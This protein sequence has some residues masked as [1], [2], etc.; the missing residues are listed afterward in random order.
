MH[1]KQIIALLTTVML[2][3]SIPASVFAESAGSPVES[4]GSEANTSIT[5]DKDSIPAE[6]ISEV[7]TDLAVSKEKAETLA[8]SHVS[9]PKEYTLQGASFSMDRLAD[10]KRGVW[11]LDFVKKV[12]GKHKG[13]IY[14][15]IHA[16]TG[17]LLEFSSYVD[18]PSAK[19]SYPL[20]V[21]RDAA[22]EIAISFI[23]KHAAEYKGQVQY[24]PDYGVQ[25]LPPLTGEVRHSIRYDRIVNGITYVDNYI[26]IEVDSEG[27]VMRFSL[28]WDDTI[29]FPK[30]ESKLTLEQANAKLSELSKP[31]LQYIIPYSGQSQRQPLLSYNMPTL[32][33]NAADGKL[34]TDPY[35]RANNVSVTPLTEKPL[36]EAPKAGSLTEK[37]ALEAITS[38]F[39]LPANA[40]LVNSNYNEYNDESSGTKQAYWN[41]NWSLK[42]GKTETG[43]VSASVDS[44]TGAVRDYYYYYYDRNNTSDKVTITYDQAKTTAIETVKKHLPWATNELYLIE[45]EEGQY[46]TIDPIDSYYLNFVRKVHGATVEYDNVSVSI[47]ARTGEIRNYNANLQDYSYPEQ[48]PKLL[49]KEQAIEKWLTFYRTELTYYLAQQYLWQGQPI[50]IEKYRAMVAAGDVEAS[51][52]EYKAEA[53]LVYRLVPRLI[54]ESIFLDAESGD[55]RNRENGEATQLEKPKATDVSGHWAQRQLELMVA[56]KALDVKDGKVRPNA[57]VTRGELIKMLVLAMNSG[58]SPIL[59]GAANDSAETKNSF[60]DVATNSSYYVYVESALQQNLIDVGDGTFNA[61]GK[62]D[63]EEMSELIVRALGYNTLANYDEL[64]NVSFKDAADTERKGQAA[65]VVGLNIMS[66]SN[67]KFLPDKQVSRAEASVAFFRFLQTRADL[68]EAPLRD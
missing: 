54:D 35:N 57:I 63:R 6:V 27:H 36:G 65:I 33:I 15:R 23:N 11:G 51:E 64:F 50:P 10:G 39:K 21:E 56:Y 18:N 4:V 44:R 40:E 24:N 38:S 42:T 14:V 28:Q 47:D 37:Q 55:W 67:G 3:S 59:Y 30:V 2:A 66:L 32:A 45:A 12:N 58:R 1:R 17:Q 41:M 34:L 8:R 26:D 31:E 43:S 49:S 19:P 68:Q 9:I 22:Q 53:Q 62:V 52:V 7:P 20:K 29:E 60:N 61:E 46:D 25:L 16:D 13:S 48:A 5:L